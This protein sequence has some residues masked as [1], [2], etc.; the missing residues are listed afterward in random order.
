MHIFISV[1][2]FSILHSNLDQFS[3]CLILVGILF[4]IVKMS[5]LLYLNLVFLICLLQRIFIMVIIFILHLHFLK[6]LKGILVH[7]PS[8]LNILEIRVDPFT[9]I[10]M[11]FPNLFSLIVIII[12]L[13]IITNLI[14]LILSPDNI[15]CMRS[16]AQR[17]YS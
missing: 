5:V 13:F 7:L 4:Y 12:R 14:P 10:T 1:N 8:I 11:G 16:L 3:L 9:W 6:I 17:I 15:W 2:W